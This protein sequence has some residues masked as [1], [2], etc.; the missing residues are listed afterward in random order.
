MQT[1]ANADLAH[2]VAYSTST[3]RKK[4]SVEYMSLFRN[5]KLANQQMEGSGVCVC[6]NTGRD[7]PEKLKGVLNNS[8]A[9]LG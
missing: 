9:L 2:A 5:Q 3:G 1:F 4:W 7:R 8:K 6:L